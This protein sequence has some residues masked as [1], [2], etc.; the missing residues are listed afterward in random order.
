MPKKKPEPTQKQQGERF[1][2]EVER[3][4]ADGELNPT[5]ADAALDG[6]IRRATQKSE[7]D[8]KK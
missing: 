1:R 7:S 4:I 3:M 6:V 5:E 8:G 2:A